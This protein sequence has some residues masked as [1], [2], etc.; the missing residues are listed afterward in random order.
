MKIAIYAICKNEAQFLDRFL[1]SAQDA[2]EIV[3]CDTGSTDDTWERLIELWKKN[4]HKMD[5][6]RIS[7]NPWRFDDARNASLALVSADV[8]VCICL[9][10]DE[11][12]QPEWRK[13]IEEAWTPE[14]TR[15]R[16]NYIWN[17]VDGK[18]GV[19]Y[20]ADK[21]HTRSGYKWKAP[22]HETLVRASNA[23]TPEVQ[24]FT[25]FTLIHHHADETKPRSQYLPLLSL[26]VQEDPNDDRMLHYYARELMYYGLY[27]PALETFGEHFTLAKYVW[28]PERAASARY[29]GDCAWALGNQAEAIQW[30]FKAIETDPTAREGWVSL[31]Q[32]Y[33]SQENWEGC[34]WACENALSIVDKPNTYICWVEAWS[35]WPELMLEEASKKLTFIE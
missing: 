21:I 2:D 29:A 25:D 4:S 16:Y 17:W 14:T 6:N 19:T 3:I 15:L 7:V 13:A 26:A 28:P 18:P 9:D 22:V 1:E 31:A 27:E 8:D 23:V 10:L 5:V 33:R 35:N 20:Y 12:L 32:A 30:F 34:K 24:T 11:V